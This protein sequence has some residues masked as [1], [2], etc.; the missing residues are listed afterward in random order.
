M[1]PRIDTLDLRKPRVLAAAEMASF[2]DWQPGWPEFPKRLQR[3][4]DGGRMTTSSTWKIT[5]QADVVCAVGRL[6]RV[7]DS[8]DALART[9]LRRKPRVGG[10]KPG[11]PVIIKHPVAATPPL[12]RPPDERRPPRRQSDGA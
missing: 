3:F 6:E 11:D 4:I 10:R 1:T 9:L 7:A 2:W 12:P 5:I 8:V